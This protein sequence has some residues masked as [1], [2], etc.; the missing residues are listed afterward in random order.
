MFTYNE[1]QINPQ[2]ST[3]TLEETTITPTNS[4]ESSSTV[5]ILLNDVDEI[6][7][8]NDLIDNANNLNETPNLN[9]S[10]SDLT[11]IRFIIPAPHVHF[12]ENSQIYFKYEHIILKS[13]DQSYHGHLEGATDTL[14]DV[15]SDLLRNFTEKMFVG[16]NSMSEIKNSES[17]GKILA[18]RLGFFYKII[19]ERGEGVFF[20]VAPVEYDVIKVP[21]FRHL[22]GVKQHY[23]RLN[24][25]LNYAL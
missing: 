14:I 13:D 2:N 17:E 7:N 12:D 16:N 5:K 9:G 6:E 24:K 21:P 10:E 8:I 19:K 23:Q 11:P 1:E 20:E 3:T 15:E 18:N 4:D 25:W 22:Q